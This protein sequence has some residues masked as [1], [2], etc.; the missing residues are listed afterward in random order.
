MDVLDALSAQGRQVLTIMIT[1]YATFETA[2]YAT[3]LG[4]YDFLAKPFTPG[5]IEVHGPQGHRPADPRQAGPQARRGEAQVRFNFISRAR[6]R[7]Q[8]AAKR[9]RRLPQHPA[10]TARTDETADDRPQHRAHRRHE[11]ADPRPA[12]PDA[13]RVGQGERV[14]KRLDLR[15][16]AKASMELFAVRRR[17]AAAS[18]SSSRPTGAS[19]CCRRRRDRDGAEQPVSN[20]VKY[21]RDGGKVTVT[22]DAQGRRR[23]HRRGRHRHRTQP[24]GGRQALRRVRPHQERTHRQ[25]LGSGLGLSTVRKIANCTTARQGREPAA[26][27]RRSR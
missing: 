11:Q 7:A 9:G 20:A 4:A 6:P 12:R 8:V 27:A 13:H 10:A 5:R 3:K 24:R 1:A 16:L 17:S 2:V 14:I 15:E 22:H 21:N 23:A 18:P 25:I 26:S 19:S